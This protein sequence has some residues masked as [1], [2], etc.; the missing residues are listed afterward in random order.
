MVKS[1]SL[2]GGRDFG[3]PVMGVEG[4]MEEK[5]KIYMWDVENDCVLAW[6]VRTPVDAKG[7]CTA[8]QGVSEPKR[9]E[10][11]TCVPVLVA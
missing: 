6:E 5:E 8:C 7:T 1:A 10:E 3:G 4:Q 2:Q 11:V 9:E